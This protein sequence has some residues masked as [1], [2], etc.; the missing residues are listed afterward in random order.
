MKHAKKIC[1]DAD[2]SLINKAS[3]VLGRH[4]TWDGYDK[5]HVVRKYLPR[6]QVELVRDALPEALKPFLMGVNFSEIRLLAPHIHLEEQCVLNFYKVTHGE[7]TSF[8]EGEIERD[9]R[10]TNDNGNGYVNVNPKKLTKVES[11]KASAGDVWLLNTRQP[12]SVSIDGDTRLKN[13]KYAPKDD[14]VRLI[15]QA[16]LDFPYVKA[17]AC[18]EQAVC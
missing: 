16:Y 12:H 18:F 11:F 7:I 10:G 4:G 17:A 6:K 13:W 2:L 14:N 1:I 5:H 3:V 15:V 9:D 8:W